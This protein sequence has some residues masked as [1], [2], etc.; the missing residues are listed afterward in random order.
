VP[1][2]LVQ[3][4]HSRSGSGLKTPHLTETKWGREHSVY[5]FSDGNLERLWGLGL[6]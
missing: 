3:K 4:D 6:F 5:S 2:P 1:M